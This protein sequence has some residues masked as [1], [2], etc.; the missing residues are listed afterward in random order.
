MNFPDAVWPSRSRYITFSDPVAGKLVTTC[1][2]KPGTVAVVVPFLSVI[3]ISAFRPCCVT[4]AIGLK[5]SA[6]GCPSCPSVPSVPFV[7]LAVV[8][9]L[10][11]V[12][13][14]VAPEEV[15]VTVAIGLK[16]SAPSAPSVPFIPGSPFSPLGIPK[17]RL[18]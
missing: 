2:P 10:L 15:C 1:A 12:I 13:E 9:P 6:P 3:E 11:S 14:I 4:V 16:P 7:T 5:P 17:A 18:A 8:V